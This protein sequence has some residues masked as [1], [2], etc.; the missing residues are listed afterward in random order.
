MPQEWQCRHISYGSLKH[1][2][3]S[4]KCKTTTV[5]L[6]YERGINGKEQGLDGRNHGNL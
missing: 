3:D 6:F 2:F 1:I 5:I 4:L